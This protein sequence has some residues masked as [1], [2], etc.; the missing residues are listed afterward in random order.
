MATSFIILHS[1]KYKNFS[2]NAYAFIF[3]LCQDRVTFPETASFNPLN[4]ELN[5]IC[6]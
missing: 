2:Q 4:T 5:P 3:P 1:L 6:Q